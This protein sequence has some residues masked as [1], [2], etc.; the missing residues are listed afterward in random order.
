MHVAEFKQPSV[1]VQVLLRERLQPV[2]TSPLSVPPVMLGV[3]QLSLAIGVGLGKVAGLH[4][5]FEFA[6]HEVNAGGLVS[7]IRL[8]T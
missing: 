7:V 1:A 8:N 3:P 6:G 4:P 5:R 2:P